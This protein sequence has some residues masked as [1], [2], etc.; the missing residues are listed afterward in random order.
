MLESMA[1]SNLC[2]KIAAELATYFETEERLLFVLDDCF[3]DWFIKVI[4]AKWPKSPIIGVVD[5]RSV[6]GAFTIKGPSQDDLKTYLRQQ[7]SLD[8]EENKLE[9]LAE[10]CRG[11]MLTAALVAGRF[12][13]EQ[14]NYS[15]VTALLQSA[16]P[17]T[18]LFNEAFEGSLTT[19]QQA[20]FLHLLLF[21]ANQPVCC[22][23]L[24]DYAL[25][26]SAE[27]KETDGENFCD[28]VIKKHG[29][30]ICLADDDK[31]SCSIPRQIHEAALEVAKNRFSKGNLSEVRIELLHAS[32]A[33]EFAKTLHLCAKHTLS[34]FIRYALEMLP[35]CVFA[36]LAEQSIGDMVGFFDL[37][38]EFG[39]E[40]AL[41]MALRQSGSCLND[42]QKSPQSN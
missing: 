16:D 31:R 20:V 38:S 4:R 42:L 40:T 21:S 12:R 25:M 35:P 9:T 37:E 11:N 3:D 14:A 28:N 24:V 41:H 7:I 33:T 30:G 34:N 8:L 13:E 1:R 22:D 10:L 39:S 15:K 23:A 26:S 18:S 32:N 27:K 19:Q 17:V 2:S 5:E 36:D 29:L 6:A